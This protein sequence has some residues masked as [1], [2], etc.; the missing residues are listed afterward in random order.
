MAVEQSTLNVSSW[1]IYKSLFLYADSSKNILVIVLVCC[2]ALGRSEYC[3]MKF[4]FCQGTE[5]IFLLKFQCEGVVLKGSLRTNVTGYVLFRQTMANKLILKL[6]S[7]V[8][9]F[10]IARDLGRVDISLLQLAI[11]MIP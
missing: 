10:E 1:D 2:D 3:E 6:V 5:E 8:L 11:V 4:V 7:K 9:E